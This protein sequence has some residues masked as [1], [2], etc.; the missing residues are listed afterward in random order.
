VIIRRVVGVDA[1]AH[2][3]HEEISIDAFIVMQWYEVEIVKA[4]YSRED[5]DHQRADPPGAFGNVRC[6][7]RRFLL[8]RLLSAHLL[9][10]GSGGA[11]ARLLT[12]A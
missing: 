12:L 3:S 5:E 4:Q 9:S 1:L 2:E 7:Q 8:S 10:L 6:G 11:I